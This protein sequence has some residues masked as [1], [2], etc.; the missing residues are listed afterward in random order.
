VGLGVIAKEDLFFDTNPMS[1]W[2]AQEP[3]ARGGKI[4]GLI[5]AYSHF[6]YFKIIIISISIYDFFSVKGCI[7][8]FLLKN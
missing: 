8:L 4:F 2:E 7:Y 6:I 1:P 5:Q 3:H